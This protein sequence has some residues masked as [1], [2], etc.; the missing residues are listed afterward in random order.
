MPLIF[1]LLE[2]YKLL[3]IKD[4]LLIILPAKIIFS[5]FCKLNFSTKDS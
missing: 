1:L 3:N 5:L 4:E 2:S